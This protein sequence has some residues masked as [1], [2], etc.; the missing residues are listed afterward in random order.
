MRAVYFA[1]RN[2]FLFS[3]I[4]RQMSF[5]LPVDRLGETSTL[6]AFHHPAPAYPVHVLLVPKKPLATLADLDP[7]AD[8]DFLTDLYATVQK[9][10]KQLD[11]A[12]DGYRLIVNG[13]KFQDFPYLHFHLISG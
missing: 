4:L 11:L 9:L 1:A 10:V 2:P 6:L 5:A 8:S 7:V 3:F 12:E 13:G